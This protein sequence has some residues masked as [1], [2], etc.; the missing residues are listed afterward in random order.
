MYLDNS[1][2]TI[3]LVPR[4]KETNRCVSDD[5]RSFETAVFG[6]CDFSRV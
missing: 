4:G 2:S 3:V 6:V 5:A 1:D